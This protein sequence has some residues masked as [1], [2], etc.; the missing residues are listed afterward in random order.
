VLDPLTAADDDQPP[1]L[2][3]ALA[4]LVIR[5]ASLALLE[6]RMIAGVNRPPGQ[7]VGLTPEDRRAMALVSRVCLTHELPDY[8]AEIHVLLDRCTT[9]LSSWLRIPAIMD[10]GLGSTVL[11]HA[12]DGAP[13]PEADELAAGFGSMT[14]R[15]EEQLFASFKGNL[16]KYSTRLGDTYYTK[17]RELVVRHPTCT[18]DELASLA[19]GIPAKLHM[20]LHDQIYESVPLGWDIGG[21]VPICAHCRN[22]L[23]Q[24]QAGLVCRTSACAH[25]NPARIATRAPAADLLRVKRG[26]LQYWVEPGLDEIRLYDALV[27]A[28]LP[29][30]LYPHRDRV[31]VA[32][33]RIGVDLKAYASPEILGRH[34]RRRRGGLVHY[35]TKLVVLPDWLVQETPLYLERLRST[36]NWPEVHCMTVQSA[37]DFIQGQHARVSEA[38]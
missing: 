31:D 37:I 35:A 12:D 36:M 26:V 9:P 28:G 22:A 10:Q 33:D 14:A 24:G 2:I 4:A 3:A 1:L 7:P 16:G 30:E 20:L 29:A 11:I 25:V 6:G 23:R 13:T 17:I 19:A 34:F 32:V 15:L 18:A 27:A 8:G 21:G 38:V 5:Q